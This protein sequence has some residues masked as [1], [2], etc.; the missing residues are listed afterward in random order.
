[1]QRKKCAALISIRIYTV[2]D[3]VYRTNCKFDKMKLTRHLGGKS[4]ITTK[5]LLTGTP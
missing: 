1:M 5:L 2:T 4:T 3:R